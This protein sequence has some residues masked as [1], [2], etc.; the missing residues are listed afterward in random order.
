MADRDMHTK[1]PLEVWRQRDK[2]I[3]ANLGLKRI[4]QQ[5]DKKKSDDLRARERGGSKPNVSPELRGRGVSAAVLS[6]CSSSAMMIN[7]CRVS[8][9]LLH[10]YV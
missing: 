4:F 6:S 7:M 5:S 9:S 2:G 8:L 1:R 10:R 3:I